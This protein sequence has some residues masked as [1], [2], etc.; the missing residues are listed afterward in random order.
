MI[1]VKALRNSPAEYYASAEKRGFG[2]EEIDG[3]FKLDE[4]WRSLVRSLNSLRKQRND[5][6]MEI[7]DI[8]KKGGNPDEFK[9][10][11]RVVNDEIAKLESRQKEVEKERDQLLSLIPNILHESVPVASGDENN[12]FVRFS[13]VARVYREDL[14]RFKALTEDNGRFEV[15]E[16]RPESHVDL[17]QKLN[18]A[19]FERAAKISGS[20]FY[21]LKNRLVKLELALIN[22]AIDFLS[23]RGFTAVSP[24]FMMNYE[25]LSR[26]TDIET[27]K[28]ALYKI[29]NDDLFMIATSEHPIGAMLMDEILDPDELPIRVA[30]ISPCFRREAGAHGKDTKGI[31]RV[32]NFYKVEQFIFCKPEDSWDFHE[33]ITKNTEDLITSL[34]IPYRVVNVCSGELSRLNSKKYDIEAWFPSQ[35][36]FREVASSSNNTD[37]QA[38]SLNIRYR[39]P[40]GNRYVH[41]LNNTGLATTRMMVCIME[42]FQT[43]RGSIR[44]PET[45]IPYAGFEEIV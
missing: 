40:E 43:D 7:G 11:V 8:I 16:K 45:L 1:D 27:F 37:F 25:S 4:E 17:V 18:I 35:G 22:Y 2:R 39:T 9:A 30:G 14:E 41:T 15:I 29:E 34:G 32:H 21:F 31:F 6:S 13:G 33:E 24:P 36:T 26:A 44:I 38:R 5:F 42:N 12:K 3:F 20:R 19:D 10:K 23:Q 28:E